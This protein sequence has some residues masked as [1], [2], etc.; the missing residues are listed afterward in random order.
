MQ[1]SRA[2]HYLGMLMLTALVTQSG[3][4]WLQSFREPHPQILQ[5]GAGLEQVIAAVNQNNGQIQSLS[6]Q[7]A[8]LSGPGL[9]TLHTQIA[10]QRQ[11]NFRL[12]ADTGI[13]GPELDL[14]S[15]EQLFWFWIRRSDPPAVYFCR[16]DQ[17]PTSQARRMIPIDPTWLVDALGTVV[18]NPALPQYGPY[19]E[20]N[21]QLRI[22]TVIETPE[23]PNYKDTFVD[24]VSAWVMEQQ[25]FDARGQMRG[26]SVTEG[27]R[28]DPRTRLY[29]PKA[30]RVECPEAQFTMHL[31]LGTVEINQLQANSELFAM[32][33]YPNTPVRDLGDPNFRFGPSPAM[34]AGH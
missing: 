6:S 25:F 33:L 15:N 3:C 31:D 4:A 17:F 16:H 8:T 30:V 32:P 1:G 21:N 24:A 14:G 20:K 5:P 34:S 7:S 29:V 19:P 10:F 12:K 22:R 23:G 2:R 28:Q 11:R 9:F 26:R 27:Y 13:T 18:F